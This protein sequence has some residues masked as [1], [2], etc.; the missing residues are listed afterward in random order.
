MGSVRSEY[1]SG[2]RSTERQIV[3]LILDVDLQAMQDSVVSSSNSL[4]GFR[5]TWSVCVL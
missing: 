3:S 2:S 5:W 4:C 1:D